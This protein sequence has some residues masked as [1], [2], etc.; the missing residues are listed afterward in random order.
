M[1]EIVIY[2]TSDGDITRCV[3][4]PTDMADLQVGEGEA[5]LEH[6]RVDDTLYKVDLSTLE[7]VSV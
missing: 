2:N 5:W 1:I 7:I 3:T 6:E 4:C